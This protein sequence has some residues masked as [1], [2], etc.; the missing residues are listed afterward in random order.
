LET[1]AQEAQSKKT[2]TTE[3][4]KEEKEVSSSFDML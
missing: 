3:A 4:G 2:Q 1:Q